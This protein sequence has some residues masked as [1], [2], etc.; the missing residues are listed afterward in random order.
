MQAFSHCS[1]AIEACARSRRFA[2]AHLR[3]DEKPR[4]MHIHDCLEMYYS[5][6]GDRQFV[7]EDS[8]Y[9]AMPGD[10]FV[11]NPFEAHRPVCAGDGAHERIVV[12]IDPAY[13][14]ALSTPQTD[15]SACFYRRPPGFCHRARLDGPERAAFT[16][17][18]QRLG[19][20]QG[21][22][23][24]LLENGVFAEL[25]VLVNSLYFDR[26]AQM[27][28]PGSR[29]GNGRA[30]DILAFLNAHI[31]QPVSIDAVAEAFYLSRGYVCRL[32]KEAT[33]T[34]INKYVVARRISVA[35]RLL[36]QGCSV[37]EACEQ[38]GFGDYAH[39]IRAF[40][41]AVGVSPKQY[42]LMGQRPHAEGE[43]VERWI[44]KSR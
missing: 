6:A 23:S 33:G 39:F 4:S 2:I 34:T 40:G 7:V 15:L 17:L 11:M 30:A 13:L 3:S 22:G 14:R 26:S 20:P 35:K 32:F 29:R 27:D 42:A 21:F 24:D 16:L 36:A 10:L 18:L 31:T 37:H 41:Q 28:L 44:E 9:D 5:M 19:A 43:Q 8:L 1:E 38:S 12:C 25:M